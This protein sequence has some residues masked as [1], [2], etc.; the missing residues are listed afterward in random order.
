MRKL[1]L[2]ITIA[3]LSK[4]AHSTCITEKEA[5]NK[6][7]MD[8]AVESA[9]AKKKSIHA[10]YYN[11]KN[12][13]NLRRGTL[14]TFIPNLSVRE[15]AYDASTAVSHAVE[16]SA[17]QTL[18]NLSKVNH[19][20]MYS[21]YMSAA[22]HDLQ[23]HKE[24]IR[25]ATETAFLSAWLIQQKLCLI[26]L[27]FDASK[28]A[29]E[30]AKNQ[31]NLN[32]LNKNDW[33][34]AKSD[35][36]AN[37][38]IVNSYQDEIA[39]AESELEFYTTK[40]IRLLPSKDDISPT[41][42]SW[43]H[44]KDITIE[45]F[46]FYYKEAIN[47]RKDLKSKQDD[48]DLKDNTS[49]YYAKQYIPSVSLIGSTSRSHYRAGG[50][51]LSKQAGIRASWSFD[52]LSSYFSAEAAK[53]EKLKAILEKNDLKSQIKFEIQ[54]AHSALQKEINNITAEKA[55]FTQNKNEFELRR[56]EVDSGLIS[57]VD[58]N[59]SEFTYEN[60]RFSWFSQLAGAS[61]RE[62]EL[63]FACAYPEK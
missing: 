26:L 34:K 30:K 20:K 48:I 35:H 47:N 6:L 62:R 54:K 42:L 11:I 61:L 28:E 36:A 43:D 59:I 21:T 50:A 38:A 63:L 25:L 31:Y 9:L 60:A 8:Q 32:L 27:Q 17:S 52:G 37:L 40:E 2:L 51:V 33:L 14:S 49:K 4:S 3:L 53:S 45:P 12:Y 22:K 7:T 46:D 15:T 39:Q 58:F 29:F 18:F 5:L 56:Q 44:K 16:V 23:A 1:Y 10:K 24:S 41:I 19:Y 55:K 57:P 13:K